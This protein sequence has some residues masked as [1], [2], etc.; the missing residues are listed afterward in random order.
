[1]PVESVLENFLAWKI[2]NKGRGLQAL[3]QRLATT[4]S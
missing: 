4:F 1:M 2:S 3:T